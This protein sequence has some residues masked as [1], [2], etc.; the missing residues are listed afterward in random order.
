MVPYPKSTFKK[1]RYT[2]PKVMKLSLL[3]CCRLPIT[4]AATVTCVCRDQK[5]GQ[6]LGINDNEDT[7][8]YRCSKCVRNARSQ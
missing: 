5:H 4:Y 1:Y 3:S 6:C 7:N 2:E 8:D